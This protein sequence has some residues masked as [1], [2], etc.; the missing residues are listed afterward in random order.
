M[1]V[2]FDNAPAVTL[3]VSGNALGMYTRYFSFE[4]DEFGSVAPKGFTTVDA[5][6][7]ATVQP[8]MINYPNI[9]NAYAYIVINQQPEPEG[10]DWRNIYPRSGDQLP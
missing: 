5:D 1:T 7:K 6:H 2:T 9:G 3:P 10:A 8:L 4:D